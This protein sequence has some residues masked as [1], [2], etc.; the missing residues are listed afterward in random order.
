[1]VAVKERLIIQRTLILSTSGDPRLLGPG[2]SGELAPDEFEFLHAELLR[3]RKLAFRW[4]FQPAR[5]RRPE[6]AIRQIAMWGDPESRTTNMGLAR[7]QI[8]SSVESKGDF[9]A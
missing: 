9:Q 7:R 4:R 6:W 1:M 2:W 5:K 3:D 8:P